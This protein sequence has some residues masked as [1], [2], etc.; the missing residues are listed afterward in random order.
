MCECGYR[1]CMV[2]DDSWEGQLMTT[3]LA[4][5]E[6]ASGI[7]A[8]S[9]SR[10]GGGCLYG[11]PGMQ[12]LQGTGGTDDSLVVEGEVTNG[13][14]DVVAMLKAESKVCGLCV[15]RST[16][17]AGAASIKLAEC[18][19][20]TLHS[21]PACDSLPPNTP[22]APLHH[23]HPSLS[24]ALSPSCHLLLVRGNRHLKCG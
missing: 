4:L 6:V 18:K 7:V 19:L 20:N 23:P 9:D 16:R 10:F 3:P 2:D 12:H 15:L 24:R 8:A 14:E 21:V 11:I 1:G 5:F 22:P 13:D 17:C